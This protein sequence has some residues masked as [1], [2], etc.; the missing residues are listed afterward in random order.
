MDVGRVLN[1]KTARSQIMG[2]I[3]FGLGMALM[4]EAIYDPR[5]GAPVNANLADYLVPT[6]ADAP[7]EID[8]SF[9]E[10]PDLLLDPL[11]SRG[12]GE[13]GITG[14]PAAV[15]N[16]VWHATGVRV[17]E[18]PITLE[19]LLPEHSPEAAPQQRAA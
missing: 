13:I 8:I 10:E 5:T 1:P 19:K 17:R 14:V 12:L 3:V 15:A 16:A 2:G 18:L 4:E 6:C 9:V 11:G 7:P